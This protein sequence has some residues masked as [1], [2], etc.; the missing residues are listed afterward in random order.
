[1]L[2]FLCVFKV[3]RIRVWEGVCVGCCKGLCKVLD[4]MNHHT[5][6]IRALGSC[7]VHVRIYLNPKPYRV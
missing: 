3:L 1:M 7:R 5:V 2:F 6:L 4:V